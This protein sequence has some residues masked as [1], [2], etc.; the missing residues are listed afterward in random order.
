MV[1]AAT[2]AWQTLHTQLE[3]A[4]RHG[5]LRVIE[6]HRGKSKLVQ[7]VPF[8]VEK[9]FIP[10]T[11]AGASTN[12]WLVNDAFPAKTMKEL[13]DLMN[14]DPGKYSVASP[15]NSN[16]RR[17]RSKCSSKISGSGR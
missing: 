3:M 14:A 10:V 4:S 8:E 11:K 7:Q 17:Y 6:H 9:D 12:S 5:L 2:L 15:G 13:I 16:C 1:P